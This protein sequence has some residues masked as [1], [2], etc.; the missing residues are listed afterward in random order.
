MSKKIEGR[1]IGHPA[2]SDLS[3]DLDPNGRDA[4][5]AALEL[6]FLDQLKVHGIL[7]KAAKAVGLSAGQV[8]AW[9]KR[10]PEFDAAVMEAIE[11]ACDYA[12]EVMVDLLA[13]ERADVRFQAAKFIL[14]NKRR[15][16]YGNKVEMTHEQGPTRYVSRVPRA[17][18][19]DVTGNLVPAR[20]EISEGGKS[21]A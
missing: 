21:D 10:E 5:H 3:F 14:Q 18:V 7:G 20:Q 6:A 9:R 4:Y 12:E 16:V 2:A 13:T 17:G 19:I 11:E 8:R 15:E 1:L